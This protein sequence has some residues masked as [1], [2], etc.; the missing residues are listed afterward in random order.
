ME[1]KFKVDTPAAK[2]DFEFSCSEAETQLLV[3][4]PVYQ[5]LGMK[6]VNE[7][8]FKSQSEQQKQHNHR[9]QPNDRFDN[10]RRTMEAEVKHQANHN[11]AVNQAI[12]GLQDQLNKMLDNIIHNKF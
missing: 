1:I 4:D 8:S 12:K 10:F 3:N 11:K 6:L 7:L 5:A 9:Q 2:V